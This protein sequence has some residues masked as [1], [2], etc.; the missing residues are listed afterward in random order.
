MV[1]LE[2]RLRSAILRGISVRYGEAYRS[3]WGSVRVWAYRFVL[4]ANRRRAIFTDPVPAPSGLLMRSLVIAIVV[5]LSAPV[6]ATRWDT[7][8]SVGYRA[9][10]ESNPYRFA[11]E[12]LD[13]FDS[14]TDSYRFPDV[15]AAD[16]L[17]HEL[18][19][20]ATLR[21]NPRGPWLFSARSRVGAHL[22]TYNGTNFDRWSFSVGAKA[23]HRRVGFFDVLYVYLPDYPI[24]PFA[25]SDIP[26][27]DDIPVY[28][29]CRYDESSVRL[30]AGRELMSGITTEGYYT[31]EVRYY[32]ENFTE[33][34]TWIDRVGINVSRSFGSVLLE[35]GYEFSRASARG[36]DESGETVETADES[37]ASYEQ[38]GFDGNVR[39]RVRFAD[40]S[41][42]VRAAA[43]YDRRAY[44]TEESLA[45]APS[46]AGR[47]DHRW[48]YDLSVEVPMTRFLVAEAGVEHRRRSVDAASGSDF[49]DSRRYTTTA[50][51]FGLVYNR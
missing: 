8:W 42:T 40:R 36:Y 20:R 27:V 1:V 47:L 48:S 14:G 11:P 13:N 31:R 24:R 39:W 50:V 51:S 30:K 9:T 41:V 4:T 43:G 18:Y 29:M 37:D 44:T 49:E 12:V 46:Y 21:Y 3:A 32:G 38:D 28:R 19:G 16:D 10:Y 25:D 26:E 5:F 6:L 23:S 22:H 15:E 45:E 35:A 33:Y 2:R 7:G 17:D 34:D